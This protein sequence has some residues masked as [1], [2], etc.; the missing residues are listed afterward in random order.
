MHYRSLAAAL[1]ALLMLFSTTSCAPFSSLGHIVFHSDRSGNSEI[2]RID[3]DGKKETRL[4]FNDAYDGFPSW[5]P[6]GTTILFQSD[7]DGTLAI[8][9]MRAD[10]SDPIRISN[11]ENGNYPKWSAEGSQIAFFSNRDG[12]TDIYSVSRDGENLR[13][14]TGS[15]YVDET[16]SWTADASVIAFQSDR[17]WRQSLVGDPPADQHSNF[18]IFTM[19]V[20]ASEVTEVTGLEFN[21]ENPS[22]NPQGDSIVFQRYIDDGLAIAVVDLNSLVSRLLT[23]PMDISGS[24]AWSSSGSQIVFDSM[25]DGN[26][27]I[28]VMD[29]D[30]SNLRQVTVTDLNENSGAALYDGP[31]TIR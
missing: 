30:G 17:T 31:G 21:D 28:Y 1:P 10:G 11:T 14:L 16:P 3:T 9:A 12:I 18:G 13:N 29:A 5:S 19:A 15:S 2:Y 24:P 22:I 8:Y 20:G 26:F 7:R 6:D 25:R 27:E 23:A 4:T